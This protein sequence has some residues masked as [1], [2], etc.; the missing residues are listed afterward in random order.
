MYF[1]VGVHGPEGKFF[2][3][4]FEINPRASHMLGKHP[5]PYLYPEFPDLCAQR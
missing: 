3:V 2:L 4:V 1:R 5:T